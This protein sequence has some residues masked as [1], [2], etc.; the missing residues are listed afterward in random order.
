MSVL[1]NYVHNR[2]RPEGI[3]TKGYVTEE[4]IEF[5]VDFIDG[6]KSVGGTGIMPRGE[7]M[8]KGNPRKEIKFEH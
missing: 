6:M 5:C 8:R 3:T 1:K 7:A 4:V 2:A